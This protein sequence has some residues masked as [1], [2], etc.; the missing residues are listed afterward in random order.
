[1]KFKS[2]IEVQAGLKDSS[3]SIGASGQI[4]SSTNGNVSWVTPTVNTV[5]RD[6]QNQ[7][8]AGVAINKGQA[9]YVTGA[10]GTNI[11]VGLASNTTEATSSKTLGLLNATVAVNGFADVVQIGK[12]A[13]LNTSAA[14]VGDAV[15]LGTNGNLIYGLANKPYA[16]AHLVFIGVVTRVNA[17][18]G[19]IFVTVQNGF[20]LNEIHDVDLKT[21][22]PVNGEILGYNGTLWINKTIA[23]WLGYTPQA[24]L[25]GTGFVKAS[26]TTI[27]YDNS[28][29]ALDSAV[30]KLTGDQGISGKKSFNLV[31]TGYNL[32]LRTSDIFNDGFIESNNGMLRLINNTTGNDLFRLEST[33]VLFGQ[34]FQKSGGISSQFLKAD[35]TVDSTAY[36]PYTGAT[37]N[38]DLGVYNLTLANGLVVGR[39]NGTWD[40]SSAVGQ[41]ALYN[42]VSGTRN[43]AIGWGTLYTSTTG[44]YN[45][46]LGHQSGYY[47]ESGSYNTLLGIAAG[48]S[49]T[50]AS[51]NTSVGSFSLFSTTT[52]VS[53]VGIGRSAGYANTIG[54]NNVFIGANAGRFISNGSSS[55]TSSSRSIYIGNYATALADS[56]INQI[57]IGSESVGLGSN[58]T[59]LGNSSTL[60]TAIYGNLLLGT[61]VDVGTYKLQVA[62]D[63]VIN[64]VR[65]GRGSGSVD[66]N[67]AIGPQALDQNTD[68][69]GNAAI[70]SAALYNNRSGAENTTIGYA[71][72][73]QN[74]TGNYNTAIGVAALQQNQSGSNNV[75]IGRLALANGAALSRDHNIAIGNLAL[76]K[77]DS[78]YNIGIGSNSLKN[79]TTGGSNIAVGY[80]SLLNNMSGNSNV[81]IGKFA[82]RSNITGEE[83]LGIGINSLYTNNAGQNNI[84]I[85][86]S[87]LY[88]NTSGNY[89][90]A[91]GF[92][93]L[94]YSTT[95]SNNVVLGYRGLYSN[96][97]GN[98]N[99]GIGTNALNNNTVGVNNIGIGTY[100]LLSNSNGINNI[101]IGKN[102]LNLTNGGGRNIAIG[103]ESLYTNLLGDYNV[104]IGDEAGKSSA[105]SKSVFIGGKANVTGPS[106]DNQIVI[107]YNA[108]GNGANT[109]VIGDNNIVTTTLKGRVILSNGALADNGTTKL[110][111][112]G[113]IKATRAVQVGVSTITPDATNVGS[114]RY[115]STA[116]NS[117]MD[118]IMQ[119]G[120][121]TYAWVNIKTNTW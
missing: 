9:V 42:N 62:T 70:G 76:N 58:T 69:Y 95:G 96:T 111:V 12:L 32:T 16:P 107:G 25:N 112:D 54:E 27:S 39:G 23:G 10:D 49:L 2:D 11:I 106:G 115:R 36:V 60:T 30:V 83:N 66:S 98:D 51:Y 35:G 17:N 1:M 117:Y 91:I 34:G 121:A 103:W 100:A 113:A 81:A 48:S 21:N 28:T 64:G 44:S 93:S 3:G 119:T 45:T 68:G 38:V 29:Y 80:E 7:V 15:W 67:L 56:Q 5:A 41:W 75:V 52:G 101:G 77:T 120:A 82:L 74:M 73:E 72:M 71:A 43:T 97:T 40:Y 84:G 61:T 18:N 87:S 22:V 108:V 63:A 90:L 33:G 86:N 118:M 14:T 89:N 114:I 8:K 4:L 50:S 59:V 78:Q 109:V 99:I 55:N 102:A 13:G 37:G 79:N 6:V 116:N 85:G 24:Q 53:N 20:E 46:A 104:A 92:Q 94:S 19:E 26:G 31:Q 88:S 105:G 65:V 57:V 110:Q 47:L